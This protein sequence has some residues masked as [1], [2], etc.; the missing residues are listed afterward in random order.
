MSSSAVRF[1]LA[2]LSVLL[3]CVLEVAPLPDFMREWRPLWLA[4]VVSYWVLESRGGFR[5]TLVWLI[6]LLQ[7][8]LYGSLL[9]FHALF[10]TLVAYV[11][12]RFQQ[13]LQIFPFW[14]QAFYLALLYVLGQLVLMLLEHLTDTARPLVQYLV[15]A[16]LSGLIWPWLYMIMHGLQRWLARH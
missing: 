10:L 2:V 8:I 4:L 12:L 15:P 14:Q 11:I 5:L 6:G 16:L 7:D 1:V 13:R 3:A 9:G